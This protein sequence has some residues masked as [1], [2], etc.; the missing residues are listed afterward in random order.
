M[1][2]KNISGQRFGRLVALSAEGKTENN[3][4]IWKCQ[5][6]CGNTKCVPISR[7]TSGKTR[8]CGCLAKEVSSQVH[9]GNT[10]RVTHAG[11]DERLYCIYRAMIRRCYN[12]NDKRFRNYGGRGIKVCDIW[13]NDYSEFRRFAVEQGYDEKA[14]YGETTI[15]RIDT[16]GDYSPGNCRFVNMKTQ[17]NNRTNNHVLL[18]AGEE[19]TISEW[20]EELGISRKTIVSR[21]H[22]GWSVEKALSEP[23]RSNGNKKKTSTTI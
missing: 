20:A 1:V 15:D 10:D 22:Y 11:S 19:K 4:T 17:Q 21:L 23:V 14:K 12:K 9:K 6:D 7:L 16:N 8:S 3:T 5:C 18:F 13:L 2:A